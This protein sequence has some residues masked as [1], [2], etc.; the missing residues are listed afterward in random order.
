MN[1]ETVK[2][3]LGCTY[4]NQEQEAIV[5]KDLPK[6]YTDWKKIIFPHNL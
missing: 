2:N 6:L 3:T 4:V 5:G 1:Y